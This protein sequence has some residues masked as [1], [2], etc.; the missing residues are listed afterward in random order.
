MTPEGVQLR[1]E[2]LYEQVWAEPMLRLAHRYGISGVALA[3][4]Y[5]KLDVPVLPLGYW[6]RKR[7]GNRPARRPLPLG[8]V[9]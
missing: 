3:K 5:R 6:E 9:S 8:P 4:I 7:W 1:R 2:D